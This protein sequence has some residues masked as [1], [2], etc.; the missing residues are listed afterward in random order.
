MALPDALR[1]LP[2]D[3]IPQG[4]AGARGED[5]V[6]AEV[7]FEQ[8]RVEGVAYCR[9]MT[10]VYA[11]HRA[12]YADDEAQYLAQPANYREAVQARQRLAAAEVA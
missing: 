3:L 6:V 9:T 7:L 4:L 2:E 12:M 1:V 8:R 10:A 5:R 11:L